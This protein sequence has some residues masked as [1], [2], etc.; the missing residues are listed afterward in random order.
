QQP[1]SRLAAERKARGT[2]LSALYISNV[3]QYLF[4]DGRF[5]AFVDNLPRFPRTEPPPVLRSVF[6]RGYR[7]LLPQSTPDSYSTSLTQR[8]DVMLQDLAAGRT[9]TYA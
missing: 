8:L 9:R 3:E 5:P 6:P 7:G 1:M 2:P 4:Q